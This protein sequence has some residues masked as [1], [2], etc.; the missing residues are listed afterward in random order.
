M[1]QKDSKKLFA[2]KYI[3]KEACLKQRAVEN[4]VAEVD[5]LRSIDHPFIV[6]LWF[7]F[8]VSL[9]SLQLCTCI[10]I[11]KNTS[12]AP[13]VSVSTT[14]RTQYLIRYLWMGLRDRF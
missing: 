7:T 9:I 14:V 5:L 11:S 8:Q 10:C 4:I 6:R 2:M 12:Q 3:N 1:E 13:T